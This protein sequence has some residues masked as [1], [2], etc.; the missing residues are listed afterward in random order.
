MIIPCLCLEHR[1]MPLQDGKR[2]LVLH[3]VLTLMDVSHPRF[4]LAHTFDHVL[5]EEDIRHLRGANL[6]N[7]RFKVGVLEVTVGFAGRC[8]TEGRL[9]FNHQPQ[10]LDD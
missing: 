8:Q 5:C 6:R 3:Q 7:R 4:R 10:P 9:L 1:R 2:G